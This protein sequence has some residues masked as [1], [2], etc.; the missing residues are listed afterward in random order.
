MAVRPESGGNPLNASEVYRHHCMGVPD[1][2]DLC[3]AFLRWYAARELTETEPTLAVFVE[4]FGAYAFLGVL[5]RLA[6]PG[7]VRLVWSLFWA[8]RSSLR[9]LQ[10]FVPD[11][12]ARVIDAAEKL[13][14][15]AAGI[16]AAHT[17]LS[18]AGR[19]GWKI[20]FRQALTAARVALQNGET[21]RSAAIPRLVELGLKVEKEM[22]PTRSSQ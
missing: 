3:D 18:F 14:G 22:T 8:A 21:L 12:D 16:L 13:A 10:I 4:R 5:F 11:G 19:L 20:Q 17:F 2:H 1:L 6:Y 15:G 9:L 7:R